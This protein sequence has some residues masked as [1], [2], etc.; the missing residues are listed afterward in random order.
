MLK[1]I[2]AE[3]GVELD[4]DTES[5]ADEFSSGNPDI[6]SG[7]EMPSD[8]EGEFSVCPISGNQERIIRRKR[9]SG[10]HCSK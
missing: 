6:Q 7:P 2:D 1:G 5:T 9:E 4:L 3:E 8:S 10:V